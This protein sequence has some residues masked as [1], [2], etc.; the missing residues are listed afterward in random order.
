MEIPDATQEIQLDGNTKADIDEIV[1]IGQ[2]QVLYQLLSDLQKVFD[3]TEKTFK[4]VPE[5]SKR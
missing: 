5:Y 2:G 1:K 3:K 4:K